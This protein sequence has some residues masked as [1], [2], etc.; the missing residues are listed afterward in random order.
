MANA[1]VKRRPDIGFR[2]SPA[3]RRHIEKMAKRR[4]ESISDYMRRLI[5]RDMTRETRAAK[6]RKK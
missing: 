6:Q 4:K 5:E 1:N 2:C 3:E